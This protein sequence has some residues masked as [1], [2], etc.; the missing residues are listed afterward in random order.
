MPEFRSLPVASLPR[1]FWIVGGALTFF[2]IFILIV[3]PGELGPDES[4]YWF[5]S[6]EFAFGYF[7]KPPLIA[8]IIGLTTGVF[9]NAEWAVRLSSPLFHF[10]TAVF[11]Y[12]TAQK[13]YDARIAFWVGLGWL[14]IPGVI[15]S[16]Y[17]ITT[18]ASLLFFWSGA[19][20]LFLRVV[21]VEKAPA[22]DFALLGAMIGFGLLSKYAM[23][24]F[25]AAIAFAALVD[26][27]VRQKIMRPAMVLTVTIAILLIAPNI[28]WNAQNDFQT[29]VH[30]A[31]NAN[32]A[33][34]FSNPQKFLSFFFAQFAIVGI[35][36]FAAL[37]YI[38]ARWRSIKAS[39]GR[40]SDQMR[41]LMIFALTPLVIVSMEAIVSRAHAN[42]AATAYPAAILL[43]TGF[44]FGAGKAWLAKI[45]VAMHLLF[46]LFFAIGISNFALIDTL[47]LS[48]ATKNIRG[49][50]AQTSAI[51]NMAAGFDA[52]V[53]DDR[54]LMGTMLYYQ[55]E[56]A[57]EIVT[58]DSNARG[59]NHYEWFKAFDPKRHRRVLFVTTRDDDAHVEYRFRNIKPLGPQTVDLGNGEMRTYHLFDI[60][61]YFGP[62][63]P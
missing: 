41:L 34:P 61:G 46:V 13:L 16:S 3:S 11:L 15:L 43:T 40:A 23:I 49:W 45:S 20:F 31:A 55:G 2:K 5:W 14:T 53:I 26:Q 1:S 22:L 50:A 12:L 7:S 56:S 58:I 21:T 48:Q 37:L 63:A 35:I 38:T 39:G 51:S 57:F 47:K 8:W 10:G 33:A 28:W 17:L 44:L 6:K 4:Q 52:I 9:G 59:D 24:Y 54:A 18:D 60:S 42:W 29:L 30:T 62:M 27:P 25:P 19:L 36:P 32:W